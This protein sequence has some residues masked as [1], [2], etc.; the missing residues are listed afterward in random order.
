MISWNGLK[1]KQTHLKI[2]DHV[3]CRQAN[4]LDWDFLIRNS[5]KKNQKMRKPNE[6]KYIYAHPTTSYCIEIATSHFDKYIDEREV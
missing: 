2:F 6:K 3:L 4:I 5:R 1:P